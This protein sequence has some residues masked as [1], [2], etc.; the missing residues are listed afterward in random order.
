MA[1]IWSGSC[2]VATMRRM[3]SGV[4][5]LAVLLT[6]MPA[7]AIE[8]PSDFPTLPP[9]PDVAG[10]IGLS[11][12]FPVGRDRHLERLRA[13]AEELGLPPA[14]ADAVAF[15]ESAYDANARGADGEVGLMQILP[16]TAAMLGHRG[17]WAELFE[18]EVNI[19]YGLRYLAKAWQLADGDLCRALM[20][21]RAGHGEERMS[22]LSI[23]YCLRARAHLAG[24]GS[25]LA[26]GSGEV[27]AKLRATLAALEESTPRA[28]RT[29]YNRRKVRTSADSR[30]FWAA[31]EKRIRAINAKLSASRLR[32]MS[33]T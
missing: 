7:A 28:P 22:A 14:L 30:R 18:P 19:R 10:L 32:I 11:P 20:K 3:G 4:A 23:R 9:P 29:A 1:K 33:G 21:Y 17:H 5:A 2:I 13:V 24:I 6:A 12:V 25:P 31:H 8:R 16:T 26:G 27:D 15:V